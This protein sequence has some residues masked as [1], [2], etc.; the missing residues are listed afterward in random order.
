MLWLQKIE[1]RLLGKEEKRFYFWFWNRV[2]TFWEHGQCMFRVTCCSRL[3]ADG[4]G[5]ARAPRVRQVPA[6]VLPQSVADA[7]SPQYWPG[8]PRRTP[9]GSTMESHMFMFITVDFFGSYV[10]KWRFLVKNRA[11]SL[12]GWE[13]SHSLSACFG[14]RCWRAAL[15]DPVCV[16]LIQAYTRDRGRSPPAG[17]NA[18][19][20][21]AFIAAAGRENCNHKGL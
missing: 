13:L 20:A 14:T 10:I 2:R 8:L 17:V 5:A 15:P 18:G 11:D 12:N 19:R 1:F 4:Q 16:F 9:T 3:A 21:Q 6:G 7:T